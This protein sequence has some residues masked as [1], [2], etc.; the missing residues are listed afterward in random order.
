VRALS[1]EIALRPQASATGQPAPW[2]LAVIVCYEPDRDALLLLVERL[3]ASPG[4]RALLVDN[5]ELQSGRA[6]TAAVGRLL[7]VSCVINSRNLGVAAAQN[8]G[9]ADALYR[10]CEF[11]LLVDQDSIPAEDM[12]DRLVGAHRQLAADGRRVA[13]VGPAFEDPRCGVVF[14][15]ARLGRLR[16][17]TF[18]PRA[19]QAVECDLLISSGCLLS[20]AALREVGNMDEGLFIDYV[21]IEW[22]Q[23]ARALGW[24]VFGVADAR[25]HHTIGERVVRLFG[26]AIAIHSPVR[27]YYL[28]RNALLFARKPYLPSRWRLHLVYRVLGQLVLFGLLIPDRIERL[29][30]MLR[31]V[32]DGV[33]GVVG[34]LGGVDGLGVIRR[35][36]RPRRRGAGPD[37]ASASGLSSLRD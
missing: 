16:M 30:W 37:G 15:F 14:P 36:F 35:S 25:M 34:R 33:R 1:A 27:H 18:V 17:Q 5:S 29:H 3:R 2:I 23:R 26:R 21:D 19:G 9:I 28:M 13:A 10:D 4:V 7:G 12:I 6:S 31:G 20:T 32:W 11:V 22:C 8:I 24:Q